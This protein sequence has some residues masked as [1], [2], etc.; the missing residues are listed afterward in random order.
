[1]DM[2][3]APSLLSQRVHPCII[4]I[5]PLLYSM[6]WSQHARTLGCTSR[7]YNIFQSPAGIAQIIATSTG[8]YYIVTG[9]NKL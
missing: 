5:L 8:F 6:V 2:Q 3:E 4:Q 9:V 1:M 7:A